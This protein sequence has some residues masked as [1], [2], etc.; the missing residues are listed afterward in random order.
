MFPQRHAINAALRVSGCQPLRHLL[1]VELP[2][3]PEAQSPLRPERPV[4]SRLRFPTCEVAWLGGTPSPDYANNIASE[5]TAVPKICGSLRPCDANSISTTHLS[6]R[7]CRARC[8][9]SAPFDALCR[10]NSNRGSACWLH[11]YLGPRRFSAIRYARSVTLDRLRQWAVAMPLCAVCVSQAVACCKPSLASCG[12]RGLEPRWLP[13][14]LPREPRGYFV[15]LVGVLRRFA[16]TSCETRLLE[17]IQPLTDSPPTVN[18]LNLPPRLFRACLWL[19][20][21]SP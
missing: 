5:S 9:Q 17:N 3:C 16:T 18:V 8:F 7:L 6:T 12:R 13:T 21:A 15:A 20:V 10:L 1:V 14:A 4:V 2:T 11:R 19:R